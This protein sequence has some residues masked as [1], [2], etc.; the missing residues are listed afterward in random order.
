MDNPFDIFMDENAEEHNLIPEQDVA[1]IKIKLGK[2]HRKESDW[3]VIKDILSAHNVIVAEPD[4]PDRRL[5]V[6]EHILCEDNALIVFTNIHDCSEHIISLN[7]RHGTPDRL[8]K[9][10]SMPFDEAVDISEEYGM[11][12]YIDLQAKTNTMCMC[13]V[14]GESKIKAVMMAKA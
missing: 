3:T 4:K 8:F 5:R 12:L 13:Y 14:P 1:L 10:G 7:R 11:E 2:S 6:K 9:L